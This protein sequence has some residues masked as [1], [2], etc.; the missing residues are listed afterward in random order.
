MEA[1]ILEAE[2]RRE[3]LAARLADP[4]LY[5]SAAADEIARVTADFNAASQRVD[6]LYAR[7]G[8][9]EQLASG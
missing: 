2:A 7:W 4:S 6:E 8:E 5:A 9:L 3:E 1:A